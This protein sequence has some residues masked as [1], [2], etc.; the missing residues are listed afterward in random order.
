LTL[1]SFLLIR[2]KVSRIY[3]VQGG[4]DIRF[5]FSPFDLPKVRVAP[6]DACRHP[7]CDIKGVI[8]VHTS[9]CHLTGLAG[10]AVAR[11]NLVGTGTA[12]GGIGSEIP[13]GSGPL[14][15]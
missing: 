2:R 10:G 5:N 14:D 12:L 4:L 15:P 11:P 7:K 9:C 1:V 13:V 8:C 3:D 6:Q